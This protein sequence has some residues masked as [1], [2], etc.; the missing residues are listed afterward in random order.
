MT[1]TA[2]TEAQ[3]FLDIY[4]LDVSE[5]PT[6]VTVARVDEDDEVYRTA[7]EKYRAIVAL[8]AD[9]HRRGQP[10]LVG[11]TSIEK[12]ELLSGYLKDKAFIKE[13]GDTLLSQAAGLTDKRD[14]AQRTYLEDVGRFLENLDAKGKGS[15]AV[16]IPHQRAECR[17]HE[18]EAF[19]VAQA[20]VP[21]GGRDRHQHG[22]SRHRH[23]TRR[24]HRF[25]FEG[26]DGR[27][28]ESNPEGE[29]AESEIRRERERIAADV[30]EKK[31][32]A[33][34]AGG[35]YVVGT[36]RHESR[37]IDNQLRGRSGR[38]G[39]PGHSKFFLSLEDDL[40]KIF[41][42]DRIDGVLQK[43]GMEEN[44]AI[45]HRW[46][47]KALE[48]AQQKVEARNFEARKY[49]LKY[50]DVMNDQRKVIFEQRIEL[51]GEQ[52]VAETIVEMRQQVV[53][54]IVAKHIPE[55]SYAEQWDTEELKNDVFNIFDVEVPA[56]DWA[57]E[58]GIADNEIRERLTT[59]ADEA[60]AKKV[61]EVGAEPMRHLEKMVLLHTLDHL[62]REHIVNLEHLR[63]VIGLRGY[64]QRDPLN[65]YK[66]ESFELFQG[67]LNQ[68]R[69]AVTGQLMHLVLRRDQPPPELAPEPLPPLEGH[70]IDPFT[71]EDEFALAEAQSSKPARRPATSA[72]G[73]ALAR[74]LKDEPVRSRK[75]AGAQNA[76]DPSTWGKVSRNA[77]CPCGSGKKYKHCHGKLSA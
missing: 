67:L 34:E 64:A 51:M 2:V 66:S 38:Q 44:E 16:A 73:S 13:L 36:E 41:A 32:K 8:I 9:C 28:A 30:T 25:P 5:I 72:A 14:A 18:Q 55:S 20:G 76:R 17:Y 33:L 26:L 4:G 1:G 49:V 50:D 77:S 59:I 54:D 57:A 46:I 10:I 75:S 39:D 11:T 47:N 71:G 19:I 31:R 12:S 43:L 60:Y 6:N 45:T 58:E 68:L 74:E 40:M 23:P 69:T 27:A 52:D 7:K 48:R 3:E 65:E 70:K 37:R 42:S 21:G 15:N 22:R 29:L 61:A 63:E 62:W 24:Q 53:E 35:L 56:A